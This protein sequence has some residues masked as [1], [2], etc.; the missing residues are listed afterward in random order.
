MVSGSTETREVQTVPIRDAA[1]DSTT[2]SLG[3][4][5]TA[6]VHEF[7][8][9]PARFA[10]KLAAACI[11]QFTKE[12]DVVLDPF[13]GGGT[14]AVE[15]QL[16]GRHCISADINSLANFVTRAKTKLYEDDSLQKVQV[17]ASQVPHISLKAM[18][19]L[20][21]IWKENRL[22]KN[23][24][25]KE[26][27]R[28]RNYMGCV[29]DELHDLKDRESDSLIRCALLRTGQW[30]LDMR[31]TIPT[32]DEF[33]HELCR[34]LEA[35]VEV[36]YDHKQRVIATWGFPSEPLVIDTA[37]A[38]IK[39]AIDIVNQQSPRLVLTSPPYPGVY[40]NYHRWKIR[41]RRES[42]VPYWLVNS[43]DGHGQAHYTMSA[44]T[45]MNEY[46][47]KL[48]VAF[49]TIASLM[50]EDSWLVQIVGFPEHTPYLEQYLQVMNS[51]GLVERHFDDAATCATDG[52]L[53][54]QVPGR[55]WWVSAKAMSEPS[56]GTR[57]EVV[58]FHQ[59]K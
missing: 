37:V 13:G 27:W 1:L 39:E 31:Q 20:S 5:R 33:R 30:A 17:F 12:G 26:T 28:I 38:D 52:R 4:R 51:S 9:Y 14:S 29:L 55:R 32:V 35:M 21:H 57:K 8:R 42:P 7:Y 24:S 48:A 36:A 16:L 19:D 2:I 23:I 54:R 56:Q 10:P 3:G 58:L 50:D 22:W 45:S 6:S 25:D 15:A 59:L 43:V 11:E 47:R 44:R 40:V 53:W 34:N 18:N 46:F 49:Q 41:S